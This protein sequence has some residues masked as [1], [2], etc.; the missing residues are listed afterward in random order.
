MKS[1]LSE[2]AHNFAT[3]Q[4]IVNIAPLGNGLI[5]DSYKVQTDTTSFVLQRINQQVFKNP[6]HIQANLQ[7][8]Q[9]HLKIQNPVAPTLQ[10][11]GLIKTRSNETGFRDAE[12]HFWR[13]LDFISNSE[14]RETLGNSEEAA[15]VGWALGHFH[16]LY[17]Q[18]NTEQLFD[19]LPGFHVT[20]SYWKIYRE[21]VSSSIQEQQDSELDFC[22]HFIQQHEHRIDCLESAVGNGLLKTRVI[23]GDPKLNNFLFARETNKI[24]SLIDLDTVKP[25]L[26]HYD[27]GD[28]LRSSC[29]IPDSNTF[30]LETASIILRHYLL[31]ARQF[32]SDADFEFLF[33]AIWLIPFE[34]GLR[35]L[36]DYLQ[37][38]WY[39]KTSDPKQNLY[40]A[41]AQFALCRDIDRKET[42]IKERLQAIK[43]LF[44]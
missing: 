30:N 26:I 12:G 37:G 16:T 44:H 7:Q 9:Q 42:A 34:L 18:L 14:S 21:T 8:L 22:Q 39:F 27:I 29:H 20:P 33:D 32:M 28:C 38:S 6:E 15:Q 43:M 4:S 31:A 40:R 25:G 2:I 11:P 3:G 35:F 24:I 19:T 1:S 41:Q 5:N 13:A 17:H 36:T 23:H 10:L